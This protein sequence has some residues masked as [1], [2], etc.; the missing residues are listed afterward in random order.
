MSS[1]IEKCFM[2][3]S[4]PE[5]AGFYD[6]K[7]G[8]VQYV[9]IDLSTSRCAIIDPV[10]NYDEQAARTS[11]ES[12]DEIMAFIADRGLAV[13]WILDTHPHADHF[14]AAALLAE[15]YGAPCAIGEKIVAVQ[16]L[17]QKIYN[18]GND[19]P[20]DGR[21]WDHL[22]TEGEL[23]KIGEL[24]GRVM[25]SQGHTLASVTYVIGDSAF[26]HDTLFMPDSGTAR[27][28]FPGGDARTLYRS[29]QQILE[30]PDATRVFTG[31]DYRPDG[32]APLW[33]STVGQQRTNNRHLC[34]EPTE[35]EYVAMR[36]ARD[37][38]LPLPVLMLA[39]L[40]VNIRGG[41]LPPTEDD[42]RSYL[43]IPLNHF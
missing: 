19:F 35:D 24:D 42:G 10:W 12:M 1:A 37:E 7:T 38:T 36:E 5:V 43:K 3:E 27:A 39:A 6:E 11:T 31:H 9:V 23:F 15:R 21:Q 25:L 40:Q 4:V 34:D 33:I 41:R 28:D 26:V 29:I 32:R 17:W 18:L 14:S 30:L 2:A 20:A 8:S 22:F 16:K 13:D